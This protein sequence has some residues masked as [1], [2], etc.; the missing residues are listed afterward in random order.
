MAQDLY[1]SWNAVTTD[2]A[3][4]P[5]AGTA[6][7]ATVNPKTILQVKAGTKIAVKEW[8]YIFTAVPTNPVQVE[9]LDTGTAGA[10]V[11]TG[12]ISNYNNP[13]GQAS[14]CNTGTAATGFNASAEG[15]ITTTRL[16]GQNLDQAIW[17]KQQY[18]LDAEPEV[19]S[20][21]FLRVRATPTST[22]ATTILCYIIWAE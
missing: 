7:L 18:P 4:A 11:T 1:V 9:L 13:S 17:F 8:G 10:T 6:T 14:L 2:L 3:T 16:L 19:L 21:N 15:S 5:M 22:V 12:S 20:G